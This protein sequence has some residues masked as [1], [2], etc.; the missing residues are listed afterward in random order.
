MVAQ[1]RLSPVLLRDDEAFDRVDLRMWSGAERGGGTEAKCGTP[2]PSKARA[3]GNYFS[4]VAHRHL[5][6]NSGRT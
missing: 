6:S 2:P 1:S 3:L 4:S 5:D